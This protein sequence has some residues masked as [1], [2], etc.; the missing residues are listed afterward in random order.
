MALSILLT[1]G[2][3]L[4]SW[5]AQP[6]SRYLL[7]VAV[8]DQHTLTLDRNAHLLDVDQ[9]VHDG[10]VYS[11]K[12]PYQPL[13]AAPAYQAFRAVGGDAFPQRDGRPAPKSSSFHWGRWWVG[14]WSSTIPAMLLCLVL[15]RLVAQVHPTVATPVALALSLGTMLLPFASALFGHVLAALF[16]AGGWLL[17][18]RPEVSPRS[19]LAAGLLLSA[20]IGTEYPLVIPVLAVVVAALVAH[21]VR[22]VAFLALGGGL[23]AIPLMLYSWAAFGSPVRTAYQGN[24]PNFQ[25]SGALGVYNLVWPQA[26]ELRKALIGDRGLF[27]LTPVCLVAVVFAVLSIVERRPTRR[28]GVLA[29]V[30]LSAMWI[31]SAG[32]DGY[33]GASPG[34]RYLIPVLPF[35][36]VPLADAWMRAPRACAAAAVIGA[37][38]MVLATMSAPLLDTDYTQSIRYWI[39]RVLGGHLADSVVGEL[40]GRG[41][42]YVVVATGLTCAASAVAIDRGST[43]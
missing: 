11:D 2:T 21:G 34:P 31:M 35:L 14:L 8:V 38:P 25:G 29:L 5:T 4:D 15:R 33:G 22:K 42:L 30:I 13:L 24:L 32:I 41:A 19:M 39:D 7:T 3:V 16:G 43:R 36:A 23:G 27:T 10:H 12:A 18:R 40:F 26:D 20:S 9:A 6:A 17:V 1:A 28:D 37:I